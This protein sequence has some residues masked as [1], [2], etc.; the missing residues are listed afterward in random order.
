MP[1]IR[2]LLVEDHPE[3]RQGLTDLLNSNDDIEVIE[4]VA[5]V[6]EA[7][8][9]L[10][11]LA[12]DIAVVDVQLPDG[13]GFALCQRIQTISPRTRCIIHTSTNVGP[14]AATAPGVDAV[15]LKQLNSSQLLNTIRK[16]AESQH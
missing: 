11:S 5:T 14:E 6:A 2:V 7:I 15:V 8:D 12:P 9:E 13:N 16:I 1:S 10:T 4:G 3:V